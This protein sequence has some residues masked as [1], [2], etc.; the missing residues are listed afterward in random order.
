[1]KDPLDPRRPLDEDE[2]DAQLSALFQS[3]EPPVPSTRFVSRT[4]DAVRREGLPMGRHPLRRPWSAP[5]GWTV[6]VGAAAAIAYAAFVSQ[7]FMAARLVSILG[8]G[9]HACAQLVR[10]AGTGLALSELCATV[11]YAVARAGATWEGATTLILT[12][13]VAGMSLMA[14]HRLLFSEG[15]VSQWQELS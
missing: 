1:M 4:L 9:F 10:L 14:L 8:L 11:G 2:L 15:E 7:P 5:L 3:V 13:A 12:A 6:I